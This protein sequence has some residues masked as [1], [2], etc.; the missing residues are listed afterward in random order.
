MIT[1]GGPPYSPSPFWGGEAQGGNIPQPPPPGGPLHPPP[2]F[3]GGQ[4]ISI[5]PLEVIAMPKKP[6]PGR[7]PPTKIPP[8]PPPP[9]FAAFL[10]M[11][12]IVVWLR[13]PI[14]GRL[15]KLSRPISSIIGAGAGGF[16]YGG[17]PRP[18]RS[19]PL[20]HHD[21]GGGKFCCPKGPSPPPP[22]A[23][24]WFHLKEKKHLGGPPH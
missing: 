22:I 16:L 7:S 17:A 4:I 5:P 8:S 13:G 10:L 2:P 11:G 3:G 23:L 1:L 21:G 15:L 20:I 18:K 14:G 24:G 19:A 6:P 12:P 9:I